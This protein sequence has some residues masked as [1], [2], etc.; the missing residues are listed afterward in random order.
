MAF[1]TGPQ[2]TR[3]SPSTEPIGGFS[4]LPTRHP[5]AGRS[6][7]RFMS[8]S[9]GRGNRTY[10]IP[11]MFDGKQLESDAALAKAKRIGLENFPK[12]FGVKDAEKWIQA[13]HGFINE[14]GNLR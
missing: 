3:L 7:V 13:N 1:L 4:R 11:T 6:N 12:F 14:D 2:S 10:V 5:S 8:V 9:P